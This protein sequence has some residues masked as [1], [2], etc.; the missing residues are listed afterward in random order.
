MNICLFP[1]IVTISLPYLRKSC[2]SAPTPL[3]VTPIV[4]AR[5]A[6]CL[7]RGG[8][9]RH[10]GERQRRDVPRFAAVPAS[11]GSPLRGESRGR[12]FRPRHSWGLLPRSQT[13]LAPLGYTRDRRRNDK[14]RCLSLKPW[15]QLESRRSDPHLVHCPSSNLCAAG[16]TSSWLP[17]VRRICG[18]IDPQCSLC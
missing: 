16:T 1:L 3:L 5:P 12:S 15:R 9:P 8:V 13:K 10:R 17:A 11:R 6:E 7:F 18:R 2:R 14:L 4:T